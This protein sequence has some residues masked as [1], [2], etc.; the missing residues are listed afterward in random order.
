MEKLA[1]QSQK[2]T[3]FAGG[4]YRDYDYYNMSDESN[5]SLWFPYDETLGNADYQ[6]MSFQI[7]IEDKDFEFF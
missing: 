1:Y 2:F 3:L 4:S 6:F 7:A 5:E